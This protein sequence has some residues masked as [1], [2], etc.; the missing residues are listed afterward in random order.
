M[1]R[2]AFFPA[3]LF[4]LALALSGTLA[5]PALAV[6]PLSQP[7][8]QQAASTLPLMDASTTLPLQANQA[9][10]PVYMDQALAREHERF[11]QFAIEQMH[12]MNANIIGG[13]NSMQVQKHGNGLYRASYKAIDVEGIVCQVRRSQSN[14]NYFVGSVLYKEHILESVAQA[15]E[16]CRRGNFQPVSEKANRIIYSSKHGGGWQ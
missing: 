9:S 16:A 11:T 4:L 12:R 13:K 10:A 7:G 15:P 1:R 8:Q 5:V 3:A 2:T 14:P 6:E